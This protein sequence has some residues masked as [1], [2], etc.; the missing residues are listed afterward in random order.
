M[1]V[2]NQHNWHWS[3]IPYV[4]RF[5]AKRLLVII[6]SLA[7]QRVIVAEK[8]NASV[9]EKWYVEKKIFIFIHKTVTFQY[10]WV[11]MIFNNFSFSGYW[12]LSLISEE[13]N[14]SIGENDVMLKENIKLI[15]KNVIKVRYI[16]FVTISG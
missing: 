9:N 6:S 16:K 10:S 3:F 15:K 8:Q 1:I 2:S 12:N 4:P 11:K 14:S 5:R 7:L 13:Q